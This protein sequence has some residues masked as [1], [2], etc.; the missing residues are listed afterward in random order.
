M[1][2]GIY[3]GSFNPPHKMHEKIAKKLIDEKY[4]DQVIFVPT[5]T[6]YEYKMNLLQNE[7]RK[8]LLEPIIEKNKSFMLSTYEFQDRTVHTCETLKHFEN[9][10]PNDK[11]YFICGADNFSY[12]DKWENGEY[13]LRH[14]KIIVISRNT[15]NLDE[16]L[17]KYKKYKDNIIVADIQPFNISSTQIRKLIHDKKYYECKNYL[18]ADVLKIIER[19]NLYLKGS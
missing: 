5:S 10:F 12:I 8:E 7:V 6:E 13:I 2:I 17:H 19:K 4:V 16:L 1:K 11:I 15:D 14:Y 18:D 3:G 9:I